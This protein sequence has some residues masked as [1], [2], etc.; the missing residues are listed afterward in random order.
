[1]ATIQA[2]C[3]RAYLLDE[4]HVVSEGPAREIVREYLHVM[5]STVSVDLEDRED[6]RGDGAVRT[7]GLRIENLD[8]DSTIR[9]GTRLKVTLSYRSDRPLRRSRFVVS[10]YDITRTGIY[11]LDSDVNSSLP[12][13]L[14]AEG[15]ITCVTEPIY[16]TPGR[17]YVN[18]SAFQAATLA[19][20]VDNAAAFDIEEDD[21]L[22]IGSVP[23]REWA[24][25]MLD[26]RWHLEDSG[27]SAA[28]AE[29]SVPAMKAAGE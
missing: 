10:I 24:V 20:Y 2:L 1:M 14:P 21:P 7:T 22:E 5:T 15:E 28:E 13:V 9:T 11:L 6:R 17:C 19:D 26:H 27:D 18:V 25:Q 16:A 3:E 4:G 29:L 23:R 12:D 8:G